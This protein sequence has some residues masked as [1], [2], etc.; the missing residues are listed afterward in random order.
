MPGLVTALLITLPVSL[1]LLRRAR[2][3]TWVSTAA[4]WAVMPVAVLIHGPLLVAFLGGT[5]RLIGKR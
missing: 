2:Q 5:L 1:L 3:E 4:F